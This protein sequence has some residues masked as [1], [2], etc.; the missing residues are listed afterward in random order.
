L[1]RHNW[2]SL[3]GLGALVISPTRELAIQ[4]FQVLKKVGQYHSFSAGLLI[5]GKDLKSEQ[6]RIQKINIL[7]ATPG[8]LLQHMDETPEFYCDNLQML[9]LDEADRI[10]DSGFERDLNAIIE[11]LPKQ[12]QTL[13]F[14]ATQTKSVK[15]LARLS[16]KNP[17][18][19]S[20]HEQAEHATPQRLSQKYL[21]CELEQ[22]LDILYN[23]IKTHLKTKMIIF[24]SS[25]KQV[26]F[27]HDTFCKMQP[28]IQLMCLHGKQK[29]HKRLV[30]FEEFCRKKAVCLFATDIA[31]RG[32]DFP[33]VDWVLQ[34]DC[35]EDVDTYIHRV[36]RTARYD[37]AGNGL[38]FLV[39]SEEKGM[40]ECFEEKKIPIQQIKVNPEKLRVSVPKLLQSY[41]FSDPEIKYLGQKAFVSYLRS[42]FLQKNKQ[43]F[44][45]HQLN[46][47]K[48]AEAL[49]LPSTPK[50][51]FGKKKKQEHVENQKDETKAPVTKIDRMF[52][53]KNMTV[54]SEHYQQMINQSDDSDSEE[55]FLTLKRE[56]H[57][58]DESV[59]V[60]QSMFNFI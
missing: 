2:N 17:E 51:K 15:D 23:F 9:V 47:D 54:L 3:D 59:L 29:Q 30:I 14:S 24:L 44:D 11:N 4:I 21:V 25:C 33:A 34:V 56:D 1:Y 39:P 53:R 7:V 45:V 60:I 55:D 12:R 42:I 18:Y 36:G 13:L 19:I 26:K 10:L 48:F 20:V 50:I 27:V 16:L 6:G 57:E 43:V 38:L 5:G 58:L 52:N 31:A 40:L 32:L 35:P 41:C 49:G 37:A 46:I 8:R 22:K 28:G